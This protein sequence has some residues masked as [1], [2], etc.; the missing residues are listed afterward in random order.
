MILLQIHAGMDDGVMF[1]LRRDD[2]IALILQLVCDPLQ[3]PVVR[4]GAAGSEKNFRRIRSDQVRDLLPRVR[5]AFFRAESG[6]IKAGRIPVNF[7]VI[8]DHFTYDF[9]LDR[10]RRRIV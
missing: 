8:R 4:L 6:G 5:E 9:L 2:M 3:D 1:D 10:S 7:R